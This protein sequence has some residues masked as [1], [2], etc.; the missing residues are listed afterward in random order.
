MKQLRNFEDLLPAWQTYARALGEA[1]AAASSPAKGAPESPRL[2]HA[3]IASACPTWLAEQG[4]WLNKDVDMELVA[5]DIRAAVLRLAGPVA[6]EA[7]DAVLDAKALALPAAVGSALGALALA[8]LTL[9]WFDNRAIGLTLGGVLGAFLVVRVIGALFDRP[10]I[11]AT[12]QRATALA[13]GGIAING[14]WRAI[15]GLTPGLMKSAAWLVAVPFLLTLV[16]RTAGPRLST[17]AERARKLAMIDRTAALAL[18]LC[19]S[20]PARLPPAPKPTAAAQLPEPIWDALVRL[21]ADLARNSSI[22]DMRDSCEDLFQRCQEAGYDWKSAPP[23][24]P[25]DDSMAEAF[26]TFGLI[27][28]GQPIR[29]SRAALTRNGEVVRRGEVRRV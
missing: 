19:W 21:K 28:P 22:D 5:T 12:A 17:S 20:H 14:V 29:T 24:A 16:K 27:A 8:P 11:L 25:Y 7:E 15:R 18:V 6:P 4:A 23:G 10:D 3:R 13:G 1:P 2:I 26:D 9:L